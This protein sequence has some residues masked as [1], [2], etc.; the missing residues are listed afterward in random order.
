MAMASG[1]SKALPDTELHEH[2]S[3]SVRYCRPRRRRK[4]ELISLEHSEHAG[5]VELARARRSAEA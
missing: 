1:L 3:A 4:A 2:P 5:I